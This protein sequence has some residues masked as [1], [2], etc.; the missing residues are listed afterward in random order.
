MRV[1]TIVLGNHFDGENYQITYRYWIDGDCE[2]SAKKIK[3][4]FMKYPTDQE[5]IKA[6][7]K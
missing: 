5:L 6:I 2:C 7:E 4:E 1:K 3:R